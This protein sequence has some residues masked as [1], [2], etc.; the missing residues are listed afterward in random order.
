MCSHG[1]YLGEGPLSPP[2]FQAGV[3]MLVPRRY[4]KLPSTHIA[5]QS[6]PEEIKAY[7]E[8]QVK[9]RIVKTYSLPN[10]SAFAVSD[11]K[12]WLH[13]SWKSKEIKAHLLAHVFLIT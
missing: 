9:V 6:G 7:R 2:L 13:T 4:R 8:H 1:V 11:R 5:I 3:M 10:M 12:T